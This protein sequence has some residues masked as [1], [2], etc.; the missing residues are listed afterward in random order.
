MQI[1]MT[2]A[3]RLRHS[4]K[5]FKA[6]Q[7]LSAPHD[8]TER[9]ARLLVNGGSAE[10]IGTGTIEDVETNVPKRDTVIVLRHRIAP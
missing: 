2:R 6:G 10:Q 5:R 3:D 4:G 8:V 9:E 7:V 1:R